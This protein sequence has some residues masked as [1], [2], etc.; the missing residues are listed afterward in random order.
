[1]KLYLLGFCNL[2][3]MHKVSAYTDINDNVGT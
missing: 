1:M 3:N 2:Q